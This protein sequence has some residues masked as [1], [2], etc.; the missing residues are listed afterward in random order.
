[1]KG[2]LFVRPIAL[3]PKVTRL[4]PSICKSSS[5]AEIWLSV[6]ETYLLF[7]DALEGSSGLVVGREELRRE[8]HWTSVREMASPYEF[9]RHRKRNSIVLIQPG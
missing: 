6:D 7:T 8:I 4:F 2:F 9:M 3:D 5:M 1:M